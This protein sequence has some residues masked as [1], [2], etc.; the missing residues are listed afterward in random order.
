MHRTFLVLL[1]LCAVLVFGDQLRDLQFGLGAAYYLSFHQPQYGPISPNSEYVPK[2]VVG[3]LSLDCLLFQHYRIEPIVA[4]G[5]DNS[6][7]TNFGGFG[8][9]ADYL[10][11]LSENVRPY[12]GIGT[13]YYYQRYYALEHFFYGKIGS[14][15]IFRN[16]LSLGLEIQLE[17]AADEPV[18]NI[19][20]PIFAKYYF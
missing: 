12:A 9:N 4:I 17:F 11:K 13:L 10:F 18:W 16:R 3:L 5:G 19:N 1:S 7:G 15:Y 6:T 20:I 8:I 14:E 2:N